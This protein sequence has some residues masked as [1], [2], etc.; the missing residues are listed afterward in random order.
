MKKAKEVKKPA[1]KKAAKKTVSK[2]K[3]DLVGG[4]PDD[5]HP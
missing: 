3:T 2:A 4:R 1:P 5:R